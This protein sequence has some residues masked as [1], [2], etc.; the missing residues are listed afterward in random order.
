MFSTKTFLYLLL[1][2]PTDNTHYYYLLIPNHLLVLPPTITYLCLLLTSLSSYA[3]YYYL[4][5]VI[6][7][8]TCQYFLLIL[9]LQCY[10]QSNTLQRHES[11]IQVNSLLLI[12][13]EQ[14]FSAFSLTFL[15]HSLKL[16]N[17]FHNKFLAFRFNTFY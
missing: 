17:L 15:N 16:Q 6:T 7:N 9:L 13:M 10:H 8:I 14:Y 5:I 11:Q 3:Y 4:P 12:I 1:K 2:T